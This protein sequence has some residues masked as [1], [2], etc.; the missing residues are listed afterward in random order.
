MVSFSLLS[1]LQP[2]FSGIKQR[3][4]VIRGICFADGAGSGPK[5]DPRITKVAVDCGMFSFV[6]GGTE[7][8]VNAILEYTIG[9]QTFRKPQYDIPFNRQVEFVDVPGHLLDRVSLFIYPEKDSLCQGAPMLTQVLS[10]LQHGEA[11]ANRERRKGDL[12]LTGLTDSSVTVSWKG[13]EKAMKYRLLEPGETMGENRSTTN[14]EIGSPADKTWTAN[15]LVKG[16]TYTLAVFT[17]GSE[18][19]LLEM[20]IT[21][22]IPLTP[23]APT[24]RA[25]VAAVIPDEY[26]KVEVG[27]TTITFNWGQQMDATL[28]IYK[29]GPKGTGTLVKKAIDVDGNDDVRISGL[30]PATTYYLHAFSIA[31]GQPYGKPLI[32]TTQASAEPQP[33]QATTA[34]NKHTKVAPKNLLLE[35][36]QIVWDP[37]NRAVGYEYYTYGAS[38][39]KGIKP[40]SKIARR[41]IHF[42]DD[43]LLR[44]LRCANAQYLEDGQELF[45]RVRAVYEGDETGPWSEYLQVTGTSEAQAP[46]PAPATA[47][48]VT[49][50]FTAVESN[51]QVHNAWAALRFTWEGPDTERIQILDGDLVIDEAPEVKNGER[52]L[53]IELDLGR[54]Y[55]LLA[56]D[57]SDRIIGETVVTTATVPKAIAQ[58]FE[59]IEKTYDPESRKATIRF[60]W[61][62]PAKG[63]IGLFHLGDLIA[64]QGCV[65]T[66]EQISFTGLLSGTR[67]Q[68]IAAD[69]DHRTIGEIFVE[70]PSAPKKAE[71]SPTARATA[72]PS[73]PAKPAKPVL[74]EATIIAKNLGAAGLRGGGKAT[75]RRKVETRLAAASGPE[76]PSDEMARRRRQSADDK[77]AGF[78][79]AL[80][81]RRA[82]DEEARKK[83]DAATP[84]ASRERAIQAAT[85][86]A[87]YQGGFRLITRAVNRMVAILEVENLTPVEAKRAIRDF[88]A[89]NPLG[90]SDD[91]KWTALKEYNR[92]ATPKGLKVSW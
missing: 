75:R 51:L 80:D 52:I 3:G 54:Q 44:D 50:E 17:L 65:T 20:P 66:G 84:E 76:V 61:Q 49:G 79:A 92:Q 36:G 87:T 69:K 78:K 30:T 64:T 9:G 71:G 77:A 32:F 83:A 24:V 27:T 29:D 53:F 6:W 67:Y 19:P 62:G 91:E 41:T 58:P 57:A 42:R 88:L 12:I 63:R 70:T 45:L 47:T 59:A 33:I 82:D 39:V 7:G 40:D 31:H 22:G 68:L 90:L 34:E 10:P 1:A 28:E 38:D 72:A 48:P 23:T 16:T 89:N 21:V 26:K 8:K 37:C 11:A 2:R 25:S 81:A 5:I 13:P 73:I 14:R 60:K 4:T 46:V 86:L 35:D 56:L 18:I 43:L 74:P 55:R 85:T 15:G